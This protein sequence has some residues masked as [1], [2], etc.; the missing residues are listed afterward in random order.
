MPPPGK[1]AQFKMAP[2][3]RMYNIN[4]SDFSD[5]KKSAVCIV[6]VNDETKSS[7]IPLIKRTTNNSVHSGQVSLPGGKKEEH[8][9]NLQDT[10]LRECYEEI[11]IKPEI[12]LGA[13]SPIYIPV[14]KFMVQPIVCFYNTLPNYNLQN[15][16]V[17]SL[18]RLPVKLLLN[19]EIIKTNTEVLPYIKL[20][21]PYFEVEG[22]KVWGATA[23]ILSELKETLKRITF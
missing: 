23:M 16:E 3:D 6:I 5:Y 9:L 20:K 1:S 13:L 17:D 7:Y 22:L 4:K 8:D 14:S 11:G 2:V 19:D 12:I 10:A 15:T 18:I 21:A